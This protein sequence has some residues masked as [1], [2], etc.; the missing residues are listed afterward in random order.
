MS[1]TGLMELK[2][3]ADQ[4]PGVLILKYINVFFEKVEH[5][6]GPYHNKHN[7]YD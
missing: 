2:Y 1:I 7:N 4:I 3:K 5:F 6:N